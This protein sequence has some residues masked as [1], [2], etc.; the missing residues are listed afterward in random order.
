[1]KARIAAALLVVTLVLAGAATPVA[2]GRTTTPEATA[3]SGSTLPVVDDAGAAATAAPNETTIRGVVLAGDGVYR[4]D[5]NT[6][7][8]WRDETTDV[9]VTV[10]TA[11]RSTVTY[12]VCVVL[13]SAPADGREVGCAYPRIDGNT[14]KTVTVPVSKWPNTPAN[15]TSAPQRVEVQLSESFGNRQLETASTTVRLVERD[16]NIDGD[17]LTNGRE[18]ELG[19][20][21]TS[22]DSDG[23]G[24]WDGEEVISYDTDPLEPDSDGDGLFDAQ[25]VNRGTDPNLADSDGDGLT[26]GVEVSKYDTNPLDDDSDGDG[27][28]D[29]AEVETYAS[30]P[31]VADTDGDGLLDGEEVHVYGT[32]PATADTDGDMLSD[33]TEVRLG[34]DPTDSLSP[35][36]PA[37]VLLGVLAGGGSAYLAGARV[38][39]EWRDR[40]D[41]RL[42]VPAVTMPARDANDATGGESAV[43]APEASEAPA[44]DDGTPELQSSVAGVDPEAL[45]S[46]EDRVRRLLSNAGGHLRQQAIVKET[47]WSKSKVSRLLSRM[48]DEGAVTKINVGRENIIS[49]PGEEPPGSQSALDD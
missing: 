25:E 30:D 24:L 6:T 33:G 40:F 18:A 22:K 16:G 49:L 26:D 46:D 23:D 9:N 38:H 35:L 10:A 12:G 36:L 41:R 29:G 43:T 39:V 31:T 27:L 1:M 42:P 19:T 14:T 20:D 5:E 37:L 21:L 34:F 45:L 28:T 47:G 32:L 17:Q 2:A 7:F 3:P 11:N 13:P 44:A 8:V 15:D 48:E 4:P